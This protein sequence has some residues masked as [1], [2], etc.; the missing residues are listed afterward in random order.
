MIA[1]SALKSREPVFTPRESE[2]RPADLAEGLQA[3][4]AVPIWVPTDD[5]VS[6]PSVS[7]KEAASPHGLLYVNFRK[8]HFFTGSQIASLG[9]LASS[10]GNAIRVAS[11][12][13][14]TRSS[15]RRMEN[16]VSI[17]TSLAREPAADNLLRIIAGYGRALFGADV[18]TVYE[19]SELADD[20]DDFG[21]DGAL[22]DGPAAQ[23][24]KLDRQSAPHI[25]VKG[26]KNIFA[27]RARSG[28]H[29][30]P[31]E[32]RRNGFVDRE[33]IISAAGIILKPDNEA[34]GVMFVN[35]RSYHEFSPKEEEFASTL[36]GT[37][38]AAIRTRR[39]M[40]QAKRK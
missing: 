35:F 16:L 26:D 21:F 4:A 9:E 28:F 1:R 34:F 30:P 2:E 38:G 27:R 12:L 37:A 5:I 24:P 29:D 32:E 40:R 14:L 10:A 15:A 3:E 33:Q 7:E 17:A 36:A 11:H 18:V 8:E 13:S 39:I 6:R 22:I 23:H 19:Y 20:F 25:L 31:R